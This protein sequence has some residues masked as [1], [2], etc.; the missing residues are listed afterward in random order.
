MGVK[1][2]S[3]E[4]V[5]AIYDQGKGPTV[6]FVM[7]LQDQLVELIQRVNTLEARVNQNSQNS[8]KPPWPSPSNGPRGLEGPLSSDG[9]R[10]PAPKSSREK[11]G[12]KPG[13]QVSHGP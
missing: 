3:V 4:E 10:K 9:Y 5:N 11:T 7:S 13:G 12:L 1:L 2:L 8:S 6:S